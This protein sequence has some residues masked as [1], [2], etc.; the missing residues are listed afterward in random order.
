MKKPSKAK[1]QYLL[2]VVRDDVCRGCKSAS[3]R[4]YRECGPCQVKR[5]DRVRAQRASK[6]WVSFHSEVMA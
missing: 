3:G 2:A 1:R 6:G 4:G 5:V